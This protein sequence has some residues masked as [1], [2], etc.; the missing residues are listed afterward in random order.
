MN[1]W[2]K[3][4]ATGGALRLLQLRQEVTEIMKGGWEM[5]F[6]TVGFTL[7][8]ER[9]PVS[10][11]N[12]VWLPSK[13][14]W[15]EIFWYWITDFSLLRLFTIATGRSC[16][17]QMWCWW[18]LMIFA[19]WTHIMANT[20][21]SSMRF[22][23]FADLSNKWSMSKWWMVLRDQS[24]LFLLCKYQNMYFFS[25]KKFLKANFTIGCLSTLGNIPII[26]FT[27]W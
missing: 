26:T 16:L 8:S 20:H 21:T 22:Q 25:I 12:G 23:N 15:P 7:I 14:K 9:K 1:A 27:T 10:L 6:E 13:E 4:Y 5:I 2:E 11:I 24:W 17:P 19:M 3:D 18:K